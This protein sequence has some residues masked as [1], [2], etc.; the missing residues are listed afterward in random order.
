METSFPRLFWRTLATLGTRG[1]TRSKCLLPA[2]GLHQAEEAGRGGMILRQRH[3]QFLMPSA[4]LLLFGLVSG[5]AQAAHQATGIKICEVDARSATIWTRLTRNAE[6]V[7]VNGPLPVITYAGRERGDAGENRPDAKPAVSF[8]EGVTVDGLQGAATGVA[9]QTRVRYRARGQTDWQN[10]RWQNVD[11]KRDFAC[12][13]R[14]AT[15]AAGTD[16]EIQVEGRATAESPVTST[17]GGQFRTSP[18]ESSVAPV[19][20]TMITGQNYYDRDLHS[21]G[22]NIYDHMRALNPDFFDSPDFSG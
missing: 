16:F 22:W 21:E 5:A 15:L 20:F 4:I 3:R 6:H 19:R 1:R 2:V 9:E 7:W 12:Q 14:L 17:L 18:P 10:T 11:T 8:P 13:H